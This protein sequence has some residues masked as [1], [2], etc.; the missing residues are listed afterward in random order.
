[1]SEEQQQ[2]NEQKSLVQHWGQL[3]T[4]GRIVHVWEPGWT[5]PRPAIVEGCSVEADSAAAYVYATTIYNGINVFHGGIPLYRPLTDDERQ[6]VSDSG[7][8]LVWAEWPPSPVM[9]PASFV[10]A[11]PAAATTPASRPVETDTA[12]NDTDGTD[13]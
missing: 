12:E 11:K 8:V 5:K 10:E 3:A 9:L 4:C 7:K 6:Q 1:M 2:Q 13:A